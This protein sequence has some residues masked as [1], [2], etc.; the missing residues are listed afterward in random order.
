[1]SWVAAAIAGS[2]VLGAVQGQQQRQAQQ[3]ANQQSADISAAQMQYS[4]WTKIAPQTAQVTPVTGSMLGGAEK[5]AL[6]GAM[7]ADAINKATGSGDLEKEFD[8]MPTNNAPVPPMG[9]G[10]MPPTDP[11]GQQVPQNPYV[12]QTMMRRPYN[13]A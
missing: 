13:L 9:A 8:K 6:T 7:Y 4:P 11:W 12:N 5:G 10:D 3:R 1:M 2:A